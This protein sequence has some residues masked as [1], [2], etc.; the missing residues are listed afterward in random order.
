MNQRYRLNRGTCQQVLDDRHT[1]T[2]SDVDWNRPDDGRGR[3][4][5]GEA[6]L[7]AGAELLSGNEGLTKRDRMVGVR[8]YTLARTEV[9]RK[10]TDG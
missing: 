9:M 4:S 1:M 2:M 8:W 6:E 7:G 10:G 3:F 5:M